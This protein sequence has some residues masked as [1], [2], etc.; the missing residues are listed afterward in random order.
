MDKHEL[1]ALERII[2]ALRREEPPI[3]SDVD[4]IEELVERLRASEE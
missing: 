2:E 3:E 1:D 4:S